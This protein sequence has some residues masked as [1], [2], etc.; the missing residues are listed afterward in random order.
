MDLKEDE[1]TKLVGMCQKF[2]K[3][4]RESSEAFL[5]DA[6][7]YNYVTPTSYLELISL[8]QTLLN[9][10]RIENKKMTNR[11]VVGLEKVRRRYHHTF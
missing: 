4:V 2:H 10:K 7:R 9:S 11:Y 5:R 1:R 6:G 8:F 3:K